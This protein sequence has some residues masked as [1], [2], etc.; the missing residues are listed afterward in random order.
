MSEAF[1]LDRLRATPN[2]LYYK[3]NTLQAS[4]YYYETTT[5]EQPEE[6]H[7]VRDAFEEDMEQAAD[8]LMSYGF[9]PE[10][11]NGWFQD[12]QLSFEALQ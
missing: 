2:A 11:V 6:S 3:H 9:D 5:E 4:P 10:V 12:K 1:S 7:P 8:N